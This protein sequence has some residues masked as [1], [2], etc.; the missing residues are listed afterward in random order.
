MYGEIAGYA[1]THDAYH[2]GHPAPDGHQL[3]RA[4]SLALERAGLD[5]DSVDTVFADGSGTK[6]GDRAE[7]KAMHTVFG[8]RVAHIPIT[9]PKSM[10]G[11]LHAAGAALDAA[12]ALLSLRDSCL[13]PTINVDR[14]VTQFGL[15]LVRDSLRQVP[16]QT[17]LIIAR[18]FGGFN[19]AVVLRLPGSP[20]S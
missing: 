16:L 8:G 19:S 5:P 10:T 9:V 2:Y 15:N 13:P 17:V 20:S 18:G 6:D 7:A 3:A 11:R 4:M 12:A 14:P 1:A